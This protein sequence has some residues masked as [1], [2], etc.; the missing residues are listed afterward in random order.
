MM[1]LDFNDAGWILFYRN[2]KIIELKTRAGTRPAPT[3]CWKI[4]LSS[5]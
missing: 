2:Y 4:G 1:T 3:I 5:S